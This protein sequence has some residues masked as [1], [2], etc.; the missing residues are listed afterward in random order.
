MQIKCRSKTKK[1]KKLTSL[2]GYTHTYD[3]KY[4]TQ[5]SKKSYAKKIRPCKPFAVP[6]N[7]KLKFPNV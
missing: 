6:A 3:R 5:K 1:L 2:L 7:V 4:D